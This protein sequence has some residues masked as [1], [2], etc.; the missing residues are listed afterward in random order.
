MTDG[1]QRRAVRGSRAYAS[2]VDAEALACAAL[3]REGWAVLGRR[4]RTAAGEVDAV[5]ERDGLVAFLEV[6]HRPTLSDAAY[7]LSARQRERLLAA[8]EI[9]LAENPGWGRA[10][11][12]FDVLLVDAA[13][14]VRRIADAFR[15]YA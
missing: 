5:A 12:R 4:L 13:G 9:L 10:G 11:V 1:R 15:R 6:K 7:A 14:A 3:E 2:G 8:A